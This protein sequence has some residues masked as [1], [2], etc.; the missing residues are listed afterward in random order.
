MPDILSSE[1]SSMDYPAIIVNFRKHIISSDNSS[2]ADA[3][4]SLIWEGRP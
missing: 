1:I 2:I 4:V 3:I